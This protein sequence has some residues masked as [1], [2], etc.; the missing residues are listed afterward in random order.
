[1]PTAHR[2][3]PQRLTGAHGPE[4]DLLQL[5]TPALLE[6]HHPRVIR[7]RVG[8]VNN[9]PNKRI[10]VV[11]TTVPPMP[12]DALSLVAGSSEAR[13][14]FEDRVS[15]PLCRNV[16]TVVEL[17]REQYLESPPPAAHRSPSPSP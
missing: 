4:V 7:D 14:D 1:M 2:P 3:A 9:Q 17:E 13:N 10:A 12:L 11:S 6:G 8:Q 15:Q 5:D 16:A